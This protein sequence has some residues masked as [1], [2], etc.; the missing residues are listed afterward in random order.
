[1]LE[2]TKVLKIWKSYIH[3]TALEKNKLLPHKDH[4]NRSFH[5][6][7]ESVFHEDLDNVYL[8]LDDEKIKVIKNNYIEL[9]K[10]NKKNQEEIF[11]LFPLIEK[12]E[13]HNG[14]SITIKYPL[15]MFNI[16]NWLKN[17]KEEEA[18]KLPI[19]YGNDIIPLKNVFSNPS[20]LGFNL[21]ELPSGLYFHDFIET[22]TGKKCENFNS[23]LTT[24]N[25][26]IDQLLID[27][28]NKKMVRKFSYNAIISS[29]SDFDITSKRLIKD[30]EYL[31][32]EKNNDEGKFSLLGVLRTFPRK[33]ALVDLT[34]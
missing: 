4:R 29:F 6:S 22:I 11:L 2:N 25:D 3:A 20:L 17:R 12:E 24:L 7:D 21:D 9:L 23:L 13:N 28:K 27:K 19:S 5:L 18:L 16:S 8:N 1:M 33:N 15:F 26:W 10:E 14:K 31:S 34:C 30:Y 32:N